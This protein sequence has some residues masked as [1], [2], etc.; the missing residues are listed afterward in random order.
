[1]SSITVVAVS[2]DRA[3]FSIVL[4]PTTVVFKKSGA[5]APDVDL[6]Y[7]MP[8][9]LKTYLNRLDN[10]GTVAGAVSGSK[11][12]WRYI[13]TGGQLILPYLD[14]EIGKAVFGPTLSASGPT[15][16]SFNNPIPDSYL[17]AVLELQ[18]LHSL[19]R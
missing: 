5:S 9:P 11:V 2:P 6:R 13:L 19:G 1:M 14:S 15:E 12:I 17:S 8:G 10:W 4:D 18:F 16:V 7:L 3:V